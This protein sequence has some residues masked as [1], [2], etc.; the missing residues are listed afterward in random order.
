M[1]FRNLIVVEGKR[2]MSL[3][4]F[5]ACT[6]FDA[7]RYN[8]SLDFW[9]QM[10]QM[11]DDNFFV[12]TDELI[13]LIG[14]KKSASNP[15]HNRS[16][17]LA[18]LRKNFKEKDHFLT[19]EVAVARKNSTGATRKLEIQM[20]KKPFKKMLLKVQTSTSEEIHD[21]FLDLEDRV[22]SYVMYQNEC[23]EQAL[24][25]ENEK[26][27]S[28]RP[29]PPQL[30]IIQRNMLQ[31]MCEQ[32][33][34]YIMTSKECARQYLWKIGRS[35]DIKSRLQTM[36]TTHVLPDSEMY[37]CHV[38]LVYDAD[39]CEKHLHNLLS[40]FRYKQSREFFQCDYNELQSLVMHVASSF[41]QDNEQLNELIARMNARVFEEI[42]TVIPEPVYL[43]GSESQVAN[44]ISSVDMDEVINQA[45]SACGLPLYWTDLQYHIK[46]TLRDK[47]IV[48]A[49]SVWK[50]AVAER[51]IPNLQ[52]VKHKKLKA[53]PLAITNGVTPSPLEKFLKTK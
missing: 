50:E 31:N 35:K 39:T 8:I 23:R 34:L 48:Y 3:I 13:D 44:S 6:G 19:T 32:N 14:F 17:L 38:S 5:L 49:N 29:A 1:E 10:N 4:D 36:N 42:N 2:D 21:Y 7:K 11:K 41:N 20:K 51:S 37:V 22:R 45:V 9:F 52:W 26:L 12:L 30:N 28:Q 46:C 18:F 15:N 24:L 53:T 25:E 43:L 27:R 33:G 16:H 47:G 40:P